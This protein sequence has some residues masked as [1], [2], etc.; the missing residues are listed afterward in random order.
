MSGSSVRVPASVNPYYSVN[1]FNN[2]IFS[3]KSAKIPYKNQCPSSEKPVFNYIQEGQ[4]GGYRKK[5]GILQYF[6]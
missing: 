2:S 1:W 5:T 3:H 4:K 6:A